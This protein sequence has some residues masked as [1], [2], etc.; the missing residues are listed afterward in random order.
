MK[1]VVT[2]ASGL[3]G[4]N[5]AIELCR[6]GHFV[7]AI[8]RSPAS[9][10][11]LAGHMIEWVAA[12]LDDVRALMAAFEGAEVVFHCAALVSILRRTTKEIVAVNVDGTRRV[13]EAVRAM[14][15]PRLV[16]CSTTAAVGLS[17][18]G[19]P[20]TEDGRWNLAE[21]GLDD[22][23]A[24][25]KRAAEGVVREAV[26]S[27]LDAVVVNPTFMLGPYDAKPSSGR[28]I[29]AV[30]EGKV[31]GHTAGRN[32]FVDVRDVARGM[33]L[34]AEK[35]RQGERYI[36]G[37]ENLSYEEVFRTIASVAGVPPPSW[38][39]P[40]IV[41][42]AIALGGDLQHWLSGVEPL[43]TSVSVRWGYTTTFQFSSA[44]AES[45]LGYTH[46]PL[47]PAIADAIAWFRGHGM[48]PPV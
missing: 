18:D 37:G 15:V 27:G 19:K 33:I 16:H 10:Q 3:L 32:N 42:A 45:E 29:L 40:R 25:T 46:G 43:V 35:G 22:G 23:Y 13:I 1:V 20:C 17:E 48:L 36:L 12:D 2:G 34:A 4:G 5:L 11:H 21:H 7:R 31:P 8:R 24:T 44:K 39:V 38:R 14:R 41:A 30:V 9:A 6:R 26:E 47:G 28:L